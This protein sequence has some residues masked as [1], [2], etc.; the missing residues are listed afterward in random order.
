MHCLCSANPWRWIPPATVSGKGRMC[1]QSV[2]PR[3]HLDGQPAAPCQ[4]ALGGRLQRVKKANSPADV[5][6]DAS[7]ASSSFLQVG[8]L[9]LSFVIQARGSGALAPGAGCTA[10]KPFIRKAPFELS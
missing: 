6:T 2:Q 7:R 4:L 10:R 5:G 9:D 1:W 3:G 8:A